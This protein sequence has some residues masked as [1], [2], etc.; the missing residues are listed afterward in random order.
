MLKLKHT[1]HLDFSYIVEE[2]TP[3]RQMQFAPIREDS[4]DL[5]ESIASDPIT[6]DNVWQL[7]EYPDPVELQESWAQIAREAR[8]DPDW[9][10]EED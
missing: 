3:K 8:E 7:D 5:T 6:H 1:H 4:D 10:F 2:L 9:H